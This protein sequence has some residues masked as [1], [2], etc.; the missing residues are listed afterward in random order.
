[1]NK[2]GSSC[3]RTRWWQ[4]LAQFMGWT[5]TSYYLF[6]AFF[7]MILLIIVVWWPLVVDYFAQVN[8]AYPI[9][10][11]LDWLLLGIF[12]FMSLS[13]M[14]RPNIKTDTWVILI[15][16]CGGLVIE[17]WGTQTRLW[18]YFTQERPPL[19]IIPAWPIAS[20][21]IDRV[22]KFMD[23]CTPKFS[24][25]WV[26]FGFYVTF[27]AFYILMTFY[28]W[29]TIDKP[30]T[31]LAII[32]C[33]LLILTPG[34]HRLALITSLAGSAL[35]VFLEIWGTTRACWTYY[36]HETP[37]IFAIFAHGLAAFA[38]WRVGNLV[39]I[40]LLKPRLFHRLR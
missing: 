8:P 36:T 28:V 15:G 22:V 38:F 35:G 20:L 25:H 17:G 33:A 40:I 29:P 26:K 21:T 5:R 39:K 12:T 11:Q 1:M 4:R 24:C 9:W 37:P 19:W 6:S 30:L 34:D 18:T 27:L 2:P 31:V 10:L 16:L 13:I 7:V 23:H 14:A 32:S 3:M